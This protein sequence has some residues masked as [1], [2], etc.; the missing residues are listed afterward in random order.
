MKTLVPSL[1][2]K[3]GSGV[4]SLCNCWKL[5]RRDGAVLGFTDHDRDL[6]FGSPAVV[7]KAA[8]GMSATGFTSR[9]NL[10]V[11]TIT[12][13]GALTSDTLTEDDLARGLWDNAAIEIYR[14]DWDQVADRVLR[15]SGN[16]GQVER[17]PLAFWSELR[18]M[19]HVLAK[20]EGRTYGPKCDATVGDTRCGVNLATASFTAT[21]AVTGLYGSRSTLA[22]TGLTG[23]AAGWFSGGLLTWTSG[24]N[25]GAAMEVKVQ[26]VS[27]ALRIIELVEDMAFDIAVADGFS[28]TAGCDHAIET[29]KSKFNNVIN[30]RGFPHMP[31]NDWL[32][33][34]PDPDEANDGSGQ[35]GAGAN[36]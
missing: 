13:Q 18:S 21:A 30:F 25:A 28:I 35:S 2:A 6:T 10:A 34:H 19:G 1:A 31:G 23:F 27:G 36:G 9:D 3:L 8:T 26:A 22:T 15:F 33:S 17:G 14:L 4:T 16:I 5:T 11:E 29:C 7:Y 20:I 24:A 32:Q 12:A